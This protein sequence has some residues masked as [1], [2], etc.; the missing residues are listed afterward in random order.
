M[1]MPKTASDHTDAMRAYAA[2]TVRDLAARDVCGFVLKKDSPTCGMAR[3]KVYP[4]AGGSPA[5]DGRGLFAEEL[6]RRMDDDSRQA[7]TALARAPDAFP[8]L[9]VPSA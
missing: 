8:V 9:G 4:E 7:R 2:R 6:I 5:R 3:V 1:V